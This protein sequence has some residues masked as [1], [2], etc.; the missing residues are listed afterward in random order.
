MENTANLKKELEDKIMEKS[1]ELEKWILETLES[2]IQVQGKFAALDVKTI[3]ERQRGLPLEKSNTMMSYVDPSYILPWQYQNNAS[4]CRNIV[5]QQYLY[6]QTWT[7]MDLSSA[8]YAIV[9]V[10]PYTPEYTCLIDRFFGDYTCNIKG[11]YRVQNPLAYM[12][13]SLR[14]EQYRKKESCC[15]RTLFHDTPIENTESICKN[16]FDWRCG[17]RY[18]YGPGVYFS[19]SPTLANRHSS[20]SRSLDRSMFMVDVLIS[21]V[22]TVPEGAEVSLPDLYYDEDYDTVLCH[23]EQTYLKSLW[24]FKFVIIDNVSIVSRHE[25]KN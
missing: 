3:D 6:P 15:V 8:S 17:R 19:I 11:L 14:L 22:L 24:I 12:K 7:E 21:K 5:L 4:E 20:R 1:C 10:F 23:G 2:R 9:P 16:N 18:K 13:F 25:K